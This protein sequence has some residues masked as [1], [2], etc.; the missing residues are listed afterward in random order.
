MNCMIRVIESENDEKVDREAVKYQERINREN[1]IMDLNKVWKEY[2]IVK[3]GFL[4][5]IHRS[6]ILCS[7]LFHVYFNT[8]ILD[9]PDLWFNKKW[10]VILKISYSHEFLVTNIEEKYT[11]KI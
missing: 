2:R 3:Y 4:F 11:V 10:K 8:N 5:F 1:F 7:L 9:C 6:P